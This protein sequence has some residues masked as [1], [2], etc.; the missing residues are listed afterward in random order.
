MLS[1]PWSTTGKGRGAERALGKKASLGVC[2][3]PG[4]FPAVWPGAIPF[5]EV[6]TVSP[7]KWRQK[8]KFLL[9]F[10]LLAEVKVAMNKTATLG[11]A[12]VRDPVSFI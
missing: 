9:C 7:V 10:L 3:L 1:R 12:R 2:H 5:F 8:K 11:Y 4:C 6:S